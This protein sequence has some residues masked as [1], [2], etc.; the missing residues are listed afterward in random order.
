MKTHK[1]S[2]LAALVLIASCTDDTPNPTALAAIGGTESS[3]IH[4]DASFTQLAQMQTG[5]YGHMSVALDG[6][7]YVIGGEASGG[8]T[9]SVEMYD[10]NT[11][12]WITRAPLPAPRYQG[13][14][15]VANGKI[16]VVGGFASGVHPTAV[17]M[18]DDGARTWTT[19]TASP[20]GRTHGSAVGVGSKVYVFGGAN[21]EAN[22]QRTDVFDVETETWATAAPM[23]YACGNYTRA[24]V[25]G[26]KVYVGNFVCGVYLIYDVDLNTWSDGPSQPHVGYFS[27]GVVD[28]RI[29][30]TYSNGETREASGYDPAVNG[31]TSVGTPPAG[32]LTYYSSSATV[33]GVIYITG[34]LEIP[35]ATYSKKLM[36]FNP[37]YAGNRRPTARANGPYHAAE[38]S[39]VSFTSSATDPDGDELTYWW[40]FGDGESSSGA[41]PTHAYADDGRYEVNLTVT[42][43]GGRAHSVTTFAN[44]RDVKHS[45]TG[46]V[47]A[48]IRA[49]DE[50][51]ATAIIVDPGTEDEFTYDVQFGDGGSMSN[52]DNGTNR[53]ISLN[54]VYETP[55]YYN[56]K[57]TVT[58]SNGDVVVIS[59]WIR[60]KLP[61]PG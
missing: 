39:V 44:I 58:S 48:T 8:S 40:D 30:T 11:N 5:R 21:A 18:S 35:G 49:G 31:S 16:V 19:T 13:T 53:N 51:D 17:Y 56:L 7:V 24:F 54:H 32:S 38:G 22:L 50:Y 4:S 37:A 52:N 29:Y 12:T 42:D 57:V 15:A 2:M 1:A 6:R 46:V 34:G 26:R 59:R 55:G 10:P 41:N 3:I 43:G 20:V 33:A 61:I 25:V 36:A 28:G 47:P 9:A 23:P 27:G 45:V 60:V 14:A